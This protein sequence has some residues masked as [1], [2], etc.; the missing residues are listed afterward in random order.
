[1]KYFECVIKAKNWISTN[2]IDAFLKTNLGIDFKTYFITNRDLSEYTIGICT[3]ANFID[4]YTRLRVIIDPRSI[5]DR[6]QGL[7]LIRKKLKTFLLLP[8][9]YASNG[10]K[11]I[12]FEVINVP[13]YSLSLQNGIYL[14]AV[15][16]YDS[17][18]PRN[19][20]VKIY[21]H[22]YNHN[23]YKNLDKYYESLEFIGK[24]IKNKNYLRYNNTKTL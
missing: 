8:V 10:K 6:Y 7:P 9:E 13:Y 1:M 23:K 17:F 21:K 11:S 18:D 16:I 2:I 19:L 20:N 12:N 15:C 24:N 14:G 3:D 5:P 4:K 22:N